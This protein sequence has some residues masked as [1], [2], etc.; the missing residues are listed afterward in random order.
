MC[1]IFINP[2]FLT[3][4]CSSLFLQSDHMSNQLVGPHEETKSDVHFWVSVLHYSQALQEKCLE[5]GKL[6]VLYYMQ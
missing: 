4:A 1:G 6:T 2:S 5:T 3:F